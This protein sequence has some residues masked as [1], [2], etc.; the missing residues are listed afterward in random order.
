MHKRL[1]RAAW[2]LAIGALLL[3][4]TAT[5]QEKSRPL[6]LV[7][8]TSSAEAK[9]AL[10]SV[11]EEVTNIGGARRTD[12]KLAA[13][14]AADPN[15]GLGRAWYAAWTTS[16]TP[17]ERTTHFARA[18]KDATAGDATTAE[19][20]FITALR[21]SQG[22]TTPIARDLMDVV[23][24]LVPDDPNVAWARLLIAENAAEARRLGEAGIKRF[25]DYAPIYNILAYRLNTDGQSEEAL[26]MVARYVELSPTHP[27]PEDSY[28]EILQLNARLDEADAHYVKALQKDPQ[29]EVAL[30]GR[31]EIAVLR[32]DFAGARPYLVQAAGMAHTP[33]RRLVIERNI[34]ATYLHEGKLKDARFAMNA[35]IK[36]AESNTLNALPDMR[37]IA[38]MT[39][40]EGNQGDALRQYVASRPAT[41]GANLPLSDA[42]FY[43]VLKQQP[44]VAAAVTA[45]EANA[46]K[47]P[48]NA[49]TQQAMYAARVVGLVMKN[50]LQGARAQQKL[51]TNAGYKAMSGA[52]LVN[53]ARKAGDAALAR[54]VRADVDA[55]KNLTLNSG[56]SRLIAQRK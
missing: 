43:A 23:L 20:L 49:D 50:D 56:F 14:V 54:E 12:R 21:E 16:F 22:G 48:D 47:A 36:T 51:I 28:A 3:A 29:F 35:V 41:A 40:L 17:A 1:T 30:V 39:A 10:V 34:A 19:L 55:V 18:L 15:F 25:P 45:M 44:D 27:N 31:A 11:L 9:A 38:L 13:V 7:S 33:A 42:G 6:T 5:A 24:K 26:R 46:A 2:L 52:F 8:T 4:T 37:A 53:A 32:G